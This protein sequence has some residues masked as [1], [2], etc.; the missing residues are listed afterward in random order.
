[1]LSGILKSTY[2][3]Y[4]EDTNAVASWLATTAQARGFEVKFLNND[5]NS[6]K[7]DQQTLQQSTGRLKGKARKEARQAE[8]NANSSGNATTTNTKTNTIAIKDFVRLAEQLIQCKKPPVRVPI[9]F[10]GAIDRAIAIRQSHGERISRNCKEADEGHT[11][12]ITI[13]KRVRDILSPQMPP[14]PASCQESRPGPKGESSKRFNGLEVEEPSEEFLRAPSTVSKW[15][16]PQASLRYEA[17]RAGLDEALFAVFLILEDYDKSYTLVCESWQGYR[18]GTLDLVSVSLMTNTAIDLARRLEDDAKALFDKYGGS[19][20]LLLKLYAVSRMSGYR[21]ERAFTVEPH[22][23]SVEKCYREASADLHSQSSAALNKCDE[24]NA[25]YSP[26]EERSESQLSHF[27]RSF[28]RTYEKLFILVASAKGGTVPHINSETYRAYDRDTDPHAKATVELYKEEMC[29]L[30]AA[31]Y[32]IWMAGQVDVDLSIKD[33]FTRGILKVFKHNKISLWLAF[34]TQIYFGIQLTLQHKVSTAYDVLQELGKRMWESLES[35]LKFGAAV[36]ASW[37]QEESGRMTFIWLMHRIFG[38]AMNHSFTEFK[39][40][41]VDMDYPA[42]CPE[43]SFELIKCHPL[44]CGLIVFDLK[45]KYHQF[46]IGTELK[47]SVIIDAHHL[48]NL[49]RKGGY[50][51]LIWP[52]MDAVT[53]LQKDAF[54]RTSSATFKDYFKL[55]AVSEGISASSFAKDRHARMTSAKYDNVRARFPRMKSVRKNRFKTFAPVSFM[56]AN[57]F[58]ATA[59]GGTELSLDDLR[60]MLATST[61]KTEKTETT[62]SEMDLNASHSGT[63]SKTE[64][65]KL[66]RSERRQPSTVELLKDFQ[67]ALEHEKHVFDFDYIKMH[68]VCSRIVYAVRDSCDPMIRDLQEMGPSEEIVL[69]ALIIKILYTSLE[70]QGKDKKR[71]SLATKILEQAAST[72]KEHLERAAPPS[73]KIE[74]Q[75]QTE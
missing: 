54:T 21:T 66:K 65:G 49:L 2:L 34:A 30:L 32:T 63:E 9:S 29:L 74:G 35:L 67:D 57:R 19:H 15:P 4:K 70:L 61:H 24:T 39:E 38:F 48:Y 53:A 10:V 5:S 6:K 1:M 7:N 20:E 22:G 13:L 36:D 46:V 52:D 31:G 14:T 51:S 40:I 75:G 26:H 18:E 72:M 42:D 12:F 68:L 47:E 3:Q 50:I 37:S 45:T 73:S 25:Q 59:D 69:G 43:A 44:L 11:F 33:E 17:E 55:W 62:M 58:E 64:A 23:K 60:K 56:F 8:K 16:D 27:E 28:F 41:W 71:S